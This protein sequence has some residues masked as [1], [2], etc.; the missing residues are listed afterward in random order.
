MIVALAIAAG[1]SNWP[2]NKRPAKTSRFLIH[3]FGRIVLIAAR[4]GPRRGFAG[5]EPGGGDPSPTSGLS[6]VAPSM[7][8]VEG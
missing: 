1:S 6:R 2:E 5:S 8:V 4:S 7:K 3:S